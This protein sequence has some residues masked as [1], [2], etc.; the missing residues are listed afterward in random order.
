MG[1]LASGISWSRRFLVFLFY[2][3]SLSIIKEVGG[4]SCLFAFC[5]GVFLF[6]LFF[7]VSPSDRKDLMC[8]LY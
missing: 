5:G 1:F 8:V 6:G 3:Y 4:F 2:L 7:I